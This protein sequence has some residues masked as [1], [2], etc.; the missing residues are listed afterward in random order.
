MTPSP[1][2]VV[3]ALGPRPGVVWLDGGHGAAGWSVVAWDPVEVITDETQWPDAA[4]HLQRPSDAQGELPF[5]A[6][7]IGYVGFGAGHAVQ[8]VP[9]QPATP[10]PPV[11]LG[12]YDAALCFD[13]AQQRWHATGPTAARA[14]AHALLDRAS[15]PPEPP[16]PSGEV[17]PEPDEQAAFEASVRQILHWIQIGD[18][19]QVNLT[20][21]V[22]V[23]HAGASW[24][25]YRR[26]RRADAP[27]GAFLKLD[28]D[29][30]VLCN[31]PELLLRV[32]G[33]QLR[34]DPIKGTRPRG[35][36]RSDDQRLRSELLASRKDL[37]ELTMIVDLVRNDLGRVA[38][39]GSVR[40][41]PRRLTQHPTV[42]H[43]SQAV[44]A[45]LRPELDVWHALAASFPPGSVTGAPKVR[46]C[47]RIRQLESHGRGVYC[48]AIGFVCDS[49]RAAF[50]VAI[51]TAVMHGT[52]AR[53]HVG[54]GIVAQSVPSDEYEETQT[55]ATALHRALVGP[56]GS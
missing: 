19:Y 46:A 38:T 55:K 14:A 42:L 2:A 29:H 31:S 40:T 1:E 50:N 20:R 48:G 56:E 7:V 16:P 3:H 30:A 9:S 4:R 39:I 24:D 35:A 8:P 27:H 54:G 36:T 5:S 25:A 10:E 18:C 26:L 12:R 43:T 49:G 41:D 51:R 52:Q 13:H 17:R 11:W 47:E 6:G 44:H 45:T 21:P 22:F 33:Q 15:A 37:A 32:E 34:S 23:Q 53:Y 28:A